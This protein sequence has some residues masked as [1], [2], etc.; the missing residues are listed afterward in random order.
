MAKKIYSVAIQQKYWLADEELHFYK[1][2]QHWL[3]DIQLVDC[4]GEIRAMSLWGGG[5]KQA[6]N[7]LGK[8]STI[9]K[10]PNS[11]KNPNVIFQK[12]QRL[13]T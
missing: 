7:F 12:I 10:K 6:G 13:N 11:T 4:Q 5:E 1:L 8:T 9:Q 2:N 3:L